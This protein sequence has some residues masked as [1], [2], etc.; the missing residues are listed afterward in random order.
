MRGGK[1]KK[2]FALVII[3]RRIS[4]PNENIFFLTNQ[5]SPDDGKGGEL[6]EVK[7][8]VE[9]EARFEKGC[10]GLWRQTN[11]RQRE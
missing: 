5:D 9:A 4:D 10:D 2:Y 6:L 7:G 1:K 3:Q 11:H 8:E